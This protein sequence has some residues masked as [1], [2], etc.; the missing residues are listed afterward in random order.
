[1]KRV[2]EVLIN[3]LIAGACGV[4]VWFAWGWITSY[5][6]PVLAFLVVVLYGAAGILSLALLLFLAITSL[7]ALF[8]AG[9]ALITRKKSDD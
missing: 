9:K 5:F 3:L 6:A 8:L 7:V 4:A 2:S 1:M